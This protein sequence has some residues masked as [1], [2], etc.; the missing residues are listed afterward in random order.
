[1][2]RHPYTYRVIR[3]P[4]TSKGLDIKDKFNSV[5]IT[6]IRVLWWNTG[7]KAQIYAFFF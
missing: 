5:L 2:C 4:H 3:T 7:F 6:K 1:M